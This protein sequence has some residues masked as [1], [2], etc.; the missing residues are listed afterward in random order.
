MVR[1]KGLPMIEI[2]GCIVLR[3]LTMSSLTHVIE[4]FSLQCLEIFVPYAYSPQLLDSPRRQIWMP[5]PYF[6]TKTVAIINPMNSIYAMELA[7]SPYP[8]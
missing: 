3:S 2:G 1:M 8:M 6:V 4:M 5:R 7:M